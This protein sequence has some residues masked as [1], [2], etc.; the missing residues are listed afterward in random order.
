M[1]PQLL[2]LSF[3][4]LI[5]CGGGSAAVV[6]DRGYWDGTVGTCVPQGWVVFDRA[7]LDTK[8]M[9]PEVLVAFQSETPVSGQFVTVTVTRESLTQPLTTPDYSEASIASVAGL[10]GY[11]ELDRQS[12]TVDGQ[13][14]TIH[15]F[16]AQPS[17]DQPESRFY[18]LS[19]V[20]NSIGYTFTAATPVTVSDTVEAQ[21][22][23]LLQKVTFVQE[24]GAV[25]E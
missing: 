24:E 16:T 17:S 3:L 12:T 20:A 15:I 2:A 23:S 6:C 1:R 13:D 14:A 9:P 8:G 22:L 21:V 5:A 4:L 10:P 19:A 18:Q 25:T 11:K 7:A